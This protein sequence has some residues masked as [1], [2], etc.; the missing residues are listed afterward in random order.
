MDFAE[1]LYQEFSNTFAEDVDNV[2]SNKSNE[3]FQYD[4]T[5][6]VRVQ[7]TKRQV[8]VDDTTIQKIQKIC[9]EAQGEKFSFVEICLG[10]STLFLGAFLGALIA[11][12]PYEFTFAGVLSYSICPI[13]GIGMGVAYFLIRKNQINDIKMFGARISEYV[14]ECLDVE[15]EEV[16]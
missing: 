2:I 12:V 7:K 9:G 11:K 15:R 6:S 1:E 16:K 14:D 3:D 4:Q 10:A 8:V 13:V 5:I